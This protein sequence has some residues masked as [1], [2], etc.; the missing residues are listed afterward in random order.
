ML[1]LLFSL[2]AGALSTLS[3]CVLPIVP[4]VMSS[5]LQVAR[6]G[7]IAL[8][9]GL[10][11]SYTLVG[12]ALALFGS[13]LGVDGPWLRHISAGLMILFGAMFLLPVLQ[14]AFVKFL[15]PLS[16]GASARLSGFK[17]DSVWAQGLLGLM[18]GLVWSPCV[19][20][21]LGAA[22]TLASQGGSALQAMLTM[23]VFGLGAALPMGLLAYGSR[24]AMAG[25]RKAMGEFGLWGKRIMGLGL[26]LVGFLVLSGADHRLEALLT[27][28]M[29]PWL[30][31]LTTRF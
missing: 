2:L 8:L 1:A 14:Q 31:D 29:P 4:I 5:A 22:V 25:R 18:L 19:G 11:L 7:P 9:I 26:V 10:A 15:T 21:T 28:L 20:P 23:F 17:A 24:A 12:T 27:G 13:S 30:V 3:P 16:D 6:F